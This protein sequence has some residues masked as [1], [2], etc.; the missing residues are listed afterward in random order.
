M[1]YIV[2]TCT[3]LSFP[4]KWHT[5]ELK[6]INKGLIIG[7]GMFISSVLRKVISACTMS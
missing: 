7:G 2:G 5:S 4:F 1:L 6:L 3:E